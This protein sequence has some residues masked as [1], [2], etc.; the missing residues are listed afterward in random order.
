MGRVYK[1]IIMAI[2]FLIRI[3]LII[4]Y[5]C[6]MIEENSYINKTLITRSYKIQIP[7]NYIQDRLY[8]ITI[9]FFLQNI[10]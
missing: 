10:F 4:Y 8:L 9:I 5:N 6:S 7:I 2:S 3:Y 1:I